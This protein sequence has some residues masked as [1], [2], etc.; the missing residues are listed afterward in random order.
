[1]RRQTLKQAR[2]NAVVNDDSDDVARLAPIF[3]RLWG[4][5]GMMSI[6]G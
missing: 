3:I 2:S 4:C 1:M 6:M 5:E